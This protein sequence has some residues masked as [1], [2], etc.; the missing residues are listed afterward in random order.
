VKTLSAGSGRASQSSKRLHFGLGKSSRIQKIIVH[1]PNGQSQE[2]KGLQANKIYSITE[3]RNEPAEISNSRSKIALAVGAIPAKKGLSPRKSIAFYPTTR[4]PIMEFQGEREKWF[5]V[6]PLEDL[7]LMVIVSPYDDDSFDRIEK[8]AAHYRE[9]VDAN[10]DLVPL[11]FHADLSE[12]SLFNRIHDKMASCNFPFRWGTLADSSR[13]KLELINGDWF[14]DGRL[15]SQ[16]FG[17]L[18]SPSGEIHHGYRADQ[19]NWETI[20]EDNERMLRAVAL[21]G[22]STQPD[23]EN[24]LARFRLPKLDRIQSRVEEL[25]YTSDAARYSEFTKDLEADAYY[26]RAWEL[27]SKGDLDEAAQLAFQGLE[28]SPKYV[29]ALIGAAKI[30][31]K[32]A[33]NAK[34]QVRIQL[35]RQSGKLLDDAIELDPTNAEAF[36]ARA[37]IYRELKDIDQALAQ[38]KQYL[39][40]KPEAWQVHAIIGRLLFYKGDDPQATEY[41]VRAFENRPTLPFVAGELGFLYLRGGQYEDA[42]KFLR[43]ASRLQPSDASII[44]RSS[45]AE[46]WS[47]NLEESIERFTDAVRTNPTKPRLKRYLAWVLATSPFESQRDGEKGIDVLEPIYNMY[48]EES[49][50][51]LEIQAACLAEFGKFS[52]AVEV[53]N[54]ALEMVE[55]ETASETY[56]D[57]QLEGL[58]ERLELYRRSKPFRMSDARRDMDKIPFKTPGR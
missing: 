58:E 4:L 13:D 50:F 5:N 22:I 6:T 45:E 19:L 24:W 34:S 37:D 23:N 47:G 44:K 38:L 55:A 56:T 30:A 7:S 33:V 16:P 29:P 39:E 32:Q 10:I 35:L 49:A 48:S 40:I 46:F 20:K 57:Q 25:G 14:Y 9:V 53:Q 3:G 11:F 21:K 42:K 31:Q 52:Q 27:S 8:W 43:L 28:K 36:I 12:S 51:V 2:F 18:L 54:K 26:N 41:L 1:W 15:P 17:F